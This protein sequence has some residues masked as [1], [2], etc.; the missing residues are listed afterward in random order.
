MKAIEQSM[1]DDLQKGHYKMKAGSV[2]MKKDCLTCA[3]EPSHVMKMFKLA[4]ISYKPSP[5]NYRHNNLSR[6]KLLN[7]R[8]TLV[9]KC[10]EVINNENWAGKTQDLSTGRIFR[11]LMQFYGTADQSHFSP[12]R[13]GV[14]SIHNTT[15]PFTNMN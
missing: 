3:G 5:V 9:D 4:C 11:D 8:K 14:L 15:G 6:Q 12:V 10:E 13:T 2:K 1:Q 7:M